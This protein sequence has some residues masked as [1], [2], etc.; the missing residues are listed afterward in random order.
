MGCKSALYAAST[1]PQSF[2]FTEARDAYQVAL[3]ETVRRFGQ[4]TRLEGRVAVCGEGYYFANANVTLTS[5]DAGSYTVS[6]YLDGNAVPG[7]TGTV[8]LDAAASSTI[9]IPAIVRNCNSCSHK[10]TVVVGGEPGT[11]A[12]VENAALS[13]MRL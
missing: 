5:S 10:L 3:F 8:T 7:A 2:S 4:C 6:L 11:E 1:E 9:C 13:L 12:V